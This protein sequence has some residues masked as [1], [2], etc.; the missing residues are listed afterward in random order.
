MPLFV[1]KPEGVEPR[2]WPWAPNKLLSPEA[3]VIERRTGMH[4]SDWSDA[5]TEGSMTALHGLLYVLL[6]REEPTL[7]WEQVVFSMSEVDFELDD[8][9]EAEAIL[10][11][12]RTAAERPLSENEKDLLTRLRAKAPAAKPEPEEGPES[13]AGP[14][15]PAPVG[16]LAPKD[17]A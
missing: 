13:E 12:E 2:K 6:K 8:E 1:Y 4:F 14:G 17:D 3:E 16:E 7:K 15:M 5:V 9:E 10:T 11:L